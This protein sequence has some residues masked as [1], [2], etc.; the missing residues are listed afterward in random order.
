MHLFWDQ[1]T[2]DKD[3]EDFVNFRVTAKNVKGWGLPSGSN[4]EGARVKTAP[5]FMNP[6]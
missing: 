4:T 5:R 1:A 6:P 2:F 3:F